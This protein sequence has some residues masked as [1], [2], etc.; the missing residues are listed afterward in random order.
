MNDIKE[1]KMAIENE[2][3]DILNIKDGVIHSNK[4]SEVDAQ[5]AEVK[6]KSVYEKM[7]Y[8]KA[9]ENIYTEM[10]NGEWQPMKE[11]RCEI[12]R[13]D[14]EKI[15]KASMWFGSH[16]KHKKEK[17]REQKQNKC[18]Y[19]RVSNKDEKVFAQMIKFYGKDVSQQEEYLAFIED[20]KAL[21][22]EYGVK[23]DPHLE[24]KL[25]PDIGKLHKELMAR[26]KL[27]DTSHGMV[28][29][30]AKHNETSR[31]L[32][33]EEEQALSLRQQD[34]DGE[35]KKEKKLREPTADEYF[36]MI[37]DEPFNRDACAQKKVLFENYSYNKFTGTIP[38]QRVKL[39][40]GKKYKTRV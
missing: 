6:L 35:E 28:L 14:T 5:K 11:M 16:L 18:L 13:P 29:K 1:T 26:P 21:R 34:Q 9:Q 7:A 15:A 8:F 39:D 36:D 19:E 17:I 27:P 33:H 2:L 38:A 25:H 12:S 30:T 4:F 23:K 10:L 3:D 32:T 37:P 22:G 24:E 20:F 31:K 40:G